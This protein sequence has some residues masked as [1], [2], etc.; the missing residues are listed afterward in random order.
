[1]FR[2]LRYFWHTYV[3]HSLFSGRFV[4]AMSL[5]VLYIVRMLVILADKLE[6]LD[7]TIN[8]FEMTSLFVVGMSQYIF[9]T[10]IFLASFYPEWEGAQGETI[11]LGKRS[12]LLGQYLNC[13]FLMLSFFV[14]V[15]LSCLLPLLTCL[16]WDNH[17]SEF[18][19]R[20]ADEPFFF[21]EIDFHYALVWR[22]NQVESPLWVYLVTFGL[23]LLCGLFMGMLVI[24][25][26]ICV[27]RGAGTAIALVFMMTPYIFDTLGGNTKFINT[28]KNVVQYYVCPYFQCNVSRMMDRDPYS[29]AA[30]AKIAVIYYLVLILIVGIY[31]MIMIKKVDLSRK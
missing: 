18:V 12:W 2:R 5:F 3:G 17:W 15:T 30:Q 29:I 26:N 8:L 24:T 11:R 20:M 28:L 23:H 10:L 21:M 9:I 19:T 1:M 6:S 31:G 27:R 7:Y 13:F 16:N 14:I 25:F 4:A 22:I